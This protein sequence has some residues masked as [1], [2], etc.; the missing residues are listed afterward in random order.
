MPKLFNI[1]GKVMKTQKNIENWDLIA[2]YYANECSQ[3]EID[4]LFQW[5]EKSEENKQLFYQVKGDLEIINLNKSMN[6]INVDSAWEKVRNRILEDNED[7]PVI[8]EPK[9]RR[10]NFST[11]LKYAASIII[12]LGLSL[13]TTKVIKLDSSKLNIVYADV[14]EQ[15]K[16][17]ILPDGTKVFL[18]S[19]SKLFYPKAFENGERRVQLEGE[20][21]FD[22][23]KNPNKPFIIESNNAE[24]KVLGTSFNVNA[25]LPNQEIEVYVETGLVQLSR[26]KNLN[27]K[28][29]INPGDIGKLTSAGIEKIKNE[30]E[31]LLAWKTKEI[32]FKEDLLGDVITTLNKVYK[33]NIVC[34]D[35]NIRNIKYTVTFRDQDIESILDVIC[36]THNIKF[37]KQSDQI[38]LINHYN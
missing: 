27:D 14:Q 19:E 25:N 28:I 31:N 2:K 38:L 24:V 5:V 11:V 4:E 26:K 21:F 15:G 6:N 36:V 30:D 35:S 13:I 3:D 17:I 16:V 8:E 1:K 33:T 29:L 20:A 37:E 34:N 9:V 7:L 23:T 12:L 22:V 10:M 32:I 18:N